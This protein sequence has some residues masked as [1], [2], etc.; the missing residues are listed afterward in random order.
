M[1]FEVSRPP[2]SEAGHGDLRCVRSV[3]VSVPFAALN[4]AAPELMRR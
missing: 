1:S 2:L 3:I 4:V